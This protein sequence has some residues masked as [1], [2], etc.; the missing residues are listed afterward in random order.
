MN[1]PDI[2]RTLFSFNLMYPS[3]TDVASLISS[4]S[5]ESSKIFLNYAYNFKINHSN[6]EYS[7]IK[8]VTNIK[9]NNIIEKN[10]F[11]SD[12]TILTIAVLD[13]MLH[14][15]NFENSIAAIFP[16]PSIISQKFPEWLSLKP[17]STTI[18]SLPKNFS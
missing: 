8:K 1:L 3:S 7:Q 6:N 17:F 4:S 10:S 13:A 12:D 2:I 18:W 9:V 14:D 16:I 5:S 11:F 15:K